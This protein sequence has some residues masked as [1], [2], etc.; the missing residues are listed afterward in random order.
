MNADQLRERRIEDLG[1]Q[2]VLAPDLTERARLWRE[3]RA[4]IAKRSPAQVRKME[5]QKGLR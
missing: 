3:L 4:E 5:A 2:L 1:H